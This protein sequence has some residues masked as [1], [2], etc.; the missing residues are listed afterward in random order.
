MIGR[1]F[2][3]ETVSY[4]NKDETPDRI[5]DPMNKVET[6][7]NLDTLQTREMIFKQS[8]SAFS[9]AVEYLFKHA[10]LRAVTYESVLKRT[11]R[12]YHAMVADWL[13]AHTGDRAGE[14][15]GLIAGH[16]EK[17]GKKE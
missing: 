10:V 7:E 3:D 15:T 9:D 6:K 17:A 14:V 8:T 16:L 13:I 5:R 4:I 12:M 2:W 11:R 1:V